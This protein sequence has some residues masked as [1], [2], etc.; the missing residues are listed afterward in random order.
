MDEGGDVDPKVD[1][2]GLIYLV[3]HLLLI[4]LSIC[5]DED[6]DVYLEVDENDHWEDLNGL[7]D[8]FVH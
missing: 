4:D 6:E 7:F 2:N 8:S 3:I 5:E 1:D